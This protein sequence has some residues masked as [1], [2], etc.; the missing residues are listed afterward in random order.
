MQYLA[1]FPFAA[2][3]K[4][5]LSSAKKYILTLN[6]FCF[7]GNSFQ[8]FELDIEKLPNHFLID[9]LP[10]IIRRVLCIIVFNTSQWHVLIVRVNLFS[11]MK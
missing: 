2:M 6:L 9:F 10:Y 11:R 3:P 1:A 4:I 8:D 5:N 7:V